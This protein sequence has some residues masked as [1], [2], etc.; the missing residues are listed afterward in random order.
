MTARSSSSGS[1]AGPPGR[2][3]A[4]GEVHLWF[5]FPDIPQLHA[6]ELLEAYGRLLTSEERRRQERYLQAVHRH[7]AL[8]A[9]ALVRTTLSRYASGVPPER[10]RFELGRHG[11]PEIASPPGSGLRFNLSHTSGLMVCG[12]TRERDVGV[13]VEDTRRRVASGQIA[14]RFFAPAEVREIEAGAGEFCDFW[15]LKEAYV[16]AR[17]AGLSLP[18]RRFS[19][20]LEGACIAVGFS[21]ELGDD[22][23]AWRFALLRPTPWHAAAVAV[24]G[25]ARLSATVGRV[26]PLRTESG[27]TCR[28]LARSR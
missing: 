8:L 6:P 15:T 24:R 25:G 10:W 18:L 4:R 28:V 17:G 9:R 22:P 12:V 20:Q 11:R 19:F 26:I 14:R 3:L 7:Q 1:S 5:L 13:D 16:K 21:P 23:A 2:T 27:Q